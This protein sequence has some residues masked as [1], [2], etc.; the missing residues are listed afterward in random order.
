MAV[1]NGRRAFAEVVAAV[2][3]HGVVAGHIEQA[4]GAALHEVAEVAANGVVG[5][6]TLTFSV[7][8]LNVND[9]YAAPPDTIEPVP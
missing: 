1:A 9:E 7:P 3:D 2:H 8:S 6:Q 4:A 5:F